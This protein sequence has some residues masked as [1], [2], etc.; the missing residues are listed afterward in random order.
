[1]YYFFDCSLLSS[2]A[3][4]EDKILNTKYRRHKPNVQVIVLFAL[5]DKSNIK[6]AMAEVVI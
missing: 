5:G 4:I 3:H 2:V 1:M 6:E